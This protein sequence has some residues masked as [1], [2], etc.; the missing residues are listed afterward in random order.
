MGRTLRRGVR[1][2]AADAWSVG[3]TKI[4]N[5]IDGPMTQ[6]FTTIASAIAAFRNAAI[7]KADFA[8]PSTKDGELYAVMTAAWRFCISSG[9]GFAAL[10]ALL[11]DPNDHVR[12]WIAAG[13]LS[14]GETSALTK[15]EVI[16]Q[17]SD[18][19][20]FTARMTLRESESGH[21]RSPFGA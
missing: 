14:L 6:T 15:L 16:A 2:L 3:R 10:R 5:A 13:L 11:D 21:L 20:G 1:L 8:T 4:P 9:E 12:C 17:R 18:L 19:L 7:A